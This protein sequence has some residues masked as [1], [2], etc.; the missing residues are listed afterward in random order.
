MKLRPI[1]EFRPSPRVSIRPGSTVRLIGSGGEV[2][3][4]LP[5]EWKV[6]EVVQGRTRVYLEVVGPAGFRTVYVAG[7]PYRRHGFK[8]RPYKVRRVG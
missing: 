5:G 2:P 3:T 7:K 8:W 6:L 4:R 1:P